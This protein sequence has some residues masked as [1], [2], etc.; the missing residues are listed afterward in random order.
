MNQALRDAKVPAELVYYRDETHLF[1]Q[2]HHRAWAE[3]LRLDWFDYWLLGRRNPD[4]SKVEQYERWDAMAK[5]WHAAK[6][7]PK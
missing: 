1:H 3:Q 5:R 7:S 6:T 2:P 4:P